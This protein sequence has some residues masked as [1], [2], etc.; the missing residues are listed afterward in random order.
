MTVEATEPIKNLTY[1]VVARGDVVL[2]KNVEVSSSRN[3]NFTFPSSIAMMP[4]AKLLVYFI[5]EDGEI[6]S[7]YVKIDFGFKLQNSVSF[8]KN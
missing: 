7:D 1:T 5:R 4:S 3:I 8:D 2:S 6:V